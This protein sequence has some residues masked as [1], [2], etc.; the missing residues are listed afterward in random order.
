[1]KN[2]QSIQYRAVLLM[3]M[4]LSVLQAQAIGT[5]IPES[6]A[7][8]AYGA[9]KVGV[10]N[11]SDLKE[12]WNDGSLTSRNTDQVDPVYKVAAG[13]QVNPYVSAEAS[14]VDLG[15]Y[16]M[17]GTS[18]GSGDSWSA[19]PISGDQEADGWMVTVTGR[20]PISK[21]WTLVGTI[22]WFWWESKETYFDGGTYYPDEKQTGSDVTFSGGFEFDPGNKDRIVCTAE[23]GHQSVGDDDYDIL[24]GFAGILYRFP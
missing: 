5:W 8:G 23:L 13:Y 7:K 19:G 18:D 3:V 17:S 24:T 1:M 9:I 11:N 6:P 2:H 12:A 22:G 14:Y 16:S 20:W 15:K 4:G 10:G 21:R